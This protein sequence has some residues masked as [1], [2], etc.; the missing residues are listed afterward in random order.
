MEDTNRNVQA[1][2]SSSADVNADVKPQ[3]DPKVEELERKVDGLIKE[4]QKQ[5]ERAQKAEAQ[6]AAAA[7]NQAG[8]TST[9]QN[10]SSD[11]DEVGRVVNPY[12]QRAVEPFAKKLSA[13]ELRLEQEGAF[14]ILAEKTGKS[15]NEVKQDTKLLKEL[16]E[17]S[18]T[19]GISGALSQQA[20]AAYDIWA[21]KQGNKQTQD[22]NRDRSISQNAPLEG[23]V[24]SPSNAF[25]MSAEEF[26]N[27]SA[28]K[29][30][31][32]ADKGD[33]K[34]EKDGNFS[35]TPK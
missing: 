31:E 19:Y 18:K 5:R 26:D 4:A 28:T 33:F 24:G 21:M 25:K 27:M 3:P 20:R 15:V 34:K 13:L 30:K 17:V 29:F 16:D 9:E 23:G 2:A 6:A 1:Q 22:Q 11:T 32:Y 7:E 10:D 8:K 35:F 12:A 14:N